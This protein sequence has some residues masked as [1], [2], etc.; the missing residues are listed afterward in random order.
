M[1]HDKHKPMRGPIPGQGPA[2]MIGSGAKANNFKES[3]GKLLKYLSVYKRTITI[4]VVF[5]MVSTSFSIVSPKLLGNIT[6]TVV[7]DFIAIS[8]YD[9]IIDSLSPGVELPAGTSGADILERLSPDQQDAISQQQREK[10]SGIDFSV[11]PSIDFDA[12]GKIILLL[13]ALYSFS[14]TISYVQSWMMTRVSQDVT[15]RLRERV[16]D[17]IN[18]LPLKYFDTHTTGDIQSRMTNDVDTIGQ[19]LNQSLTQI[20]TAVITIIGIIAMMLTISWQ[21]TLVALMVLPVSFGFIGFI[22]KKSQKLFKQ[23]ADEL[24]QING[25]IEETYGAHNVIRAYNGEQ[26]AIDAFDAINADLYKSS[27]KSQFLSGL[28]MP[29]MTFIGNIGYVLVATISGWLALKGRIGVGDIQAFIQYLQQFNHPVMQAANISN[30]LQSTAA[31][32][33]RVFEF[34]EEE[35]ETVESSASTDIKKSQGHVEIQNVTFG[36]EANK[37]VLHNVTIKVKPGQRVAIVGPTGGGKTTIVNLL[38]RFYDVD[39]GSIR[40]DGVDIRKM[41]RGLL[42]KQFGMVLQDSW[43][44]HSS[45]RDNIVYGKLDA[46][47]E[48]IE[49]IGKLAQVNH[50]VHSLPEGYE[51]KINENGDN[52]SQGE[53]QLITIARAMLADAP[54]LILDEATSSVDTRTELL[55]QKAMDQIMEGRTSFVIAHRLST[56]KNA[57]LIL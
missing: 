23:Q 44:F 11:R 19:T 50:F 10:M 38:M 14:A 4:V 13:L 2:T 9:K 8:I 3:M 51:M 37:P 29:I 31:A 22:I 30:V 33:E 32:A 7:D 20:V 27:W 17:K 24:G 54:I 55:I 18:Q 26:D 34:L 28:M 35:T 39:S 6:N 36:Y 43:L 52:I 16:F 57:D 41:Q 15:F 1:E 48:E 56:I 21:L 47:A 5:A 46:T 42:R 40:I 45:I 12:I 25:H 53:K 49:A